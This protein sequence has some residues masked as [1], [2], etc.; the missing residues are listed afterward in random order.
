MKERRQWI[1]EVATW[2]HEASVVQ[3]GH[4]LEVGVPRYAMHPPFLYSL[5]GVHGDGLSPV[6][7][8]SQ[9]I[10]VVADSIAMGTHTGTH[11]D[12]LVHV[13]YDGHLFDGT[14]VSAPGVQ[15]LGLGIHMEHAE[16]IR[17]I[18]A[19]GVLFDF[20]ALLGVEVVPG[21]YEITPEAVEQCAAKQGAE[22][23]P[24]SV[25]LFRTGWD[26][27]WD[28]PSKFLGPKIPGRRRT[29]LGFLSRSG[30]SQPVPTPCRTSRSR[31]LSLFEVHVEL[32]TKAGVFIFEC[33]D[34]RELARRRA[35]E[36]LF[37]VSPL[38]IVGA[39]G[40]PVNPVA[41]VFERSNAKEG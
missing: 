6:E 12:S 35:Y 30:S 5:T 21:E 14:D 3:L 37:A 41:I 39:T 28:E 4:K 40:S 17:P 24:G 29:L 34:L 1:G 31:R 25:V 2:L 9:R 18:I 19:P 36:F 10:S 26:T 13:A 16:A 27:Y 11:M 7:G 15:D 23:K 33:L 38:R 20:P 32:L 8:Q 22:I